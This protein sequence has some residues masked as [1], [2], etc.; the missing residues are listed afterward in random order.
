MNSGSTFKI[1]MRKLLHGCSKANNY[2]VDILGHTKC[3][4]DHLV[5]SRDISTR[6]RDAGLTLKP[7]KCLI[8]F[9]SIAFTGHVVGKGILQME[10]DKL[11]GPEMLS[12]LRQRNRF[13]LSL[14]WLGTT[15]DLS[16]PFK[17]LQRH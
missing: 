14:D 2:V 8:G 10:D 1:M 12:A 11:E 4:D 16:Q 13:V 9:E 6:A 5:P 3:W 7:S 15:G 17:M